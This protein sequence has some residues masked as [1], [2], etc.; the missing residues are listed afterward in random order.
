MSDP[1]KWTFTP[2]KRANGRKATTVDSHTRTTSATN[3]IRRKNDE[4][5]IKNNDKIMQKQWKL[6]EKN[7][8]LWEKNDEIQRKTIKHN[9]N[10]E[11]PAARHLWRIT[12]SLNIYR[13]TYKIPCPNWSFTIKRNIW[14][15]SWMGWGRVEWVGDQ[16]NGYFLFWF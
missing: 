15:T 12:I 13:F 8:K 6:W 7:E 16:L 10:Y 14:G 9:E 2:L 4:T 5:T 3:A 11:K 1:H